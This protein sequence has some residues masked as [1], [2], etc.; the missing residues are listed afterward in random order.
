MSTIDAKLPAAPVIPG[1]A[2]RVL[3]VRAPYYTQVVDG[4][5]DGAGRIL[6]E[7]GATVDLLDV[8]GALE[9]A[10][11]IR[12]AVGGRRR[13]DGFVALGCVVKGETDH[14]DHV[15]REAMAGLTLVA[16]RHGLCLGNGLL[17]VHSEAQALARS[18][19]DGH[20]KGAEAA[21]ACLLQIGAAR[22]LGAV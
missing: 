7:A 9:L 11:A 8:A 16:L 5:R 3:V 14:Y 6:G 2:P 22:W 4:L 20:N 1:P 15:C 18:G 19:R 12:L 10:G 21:A 17:T 13:F